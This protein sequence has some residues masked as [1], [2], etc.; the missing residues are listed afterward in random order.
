MHT[1]SVRANNLK[2]MLDPKSVAVVGA[3][4]DTRKPGGRVV[5]YLH[6]KHYQGKIY[7]VN[8]KVSFVN[9]IKAFAC[10]E[11]LPEIPDLVVISV[12]A[13][14]VVPTVVS[15]NA[16]GVPS[17]I[18]FS[19][20][21]SEVGTAEGLSLDEQLRDCINGSTIVSGPNCQGIINF[22]TGCIANFSSVMVASEIKVGSVGIVSQ[23][24]LFAALII[25]SLKEKSGIGYVATTGNE[26]DVEFSD[27]VAVMAED[28]KIKVIVGYLEAIRDVER[29]KHAARMAKKNNKPLIIL[30]VGKTKEAARAAQS[31]TGALSSPAFL[32]ES[33]FRSLDIIQV[34]DLD[35]LNQAA[36][37]LSLPLP[38]NDFSNLA[39]LTNSGGLGVWC[40]DQLKFQKFELANLAGSTKDSI[41]S[42]MFAFGSADNPVDIA[43]LAISNMPAVERILEHL[44]NDE[45]VDV[46]F[47]ILAF[48]HANASPFAQKL[49]DL[50]KKKKKTIV[51]CWISSDKE[52]QRM[53]ENNSLPVFESATEALRALTHVRNF[54]HANQSDQQSVKSQLNEEAKL[55]VAKHLERK[56]KSV[57]EY[58]AMNILKAIDIP[59][60]QIKRITEA[61][62]VGDVYKEFN[63]TVVMKVDSKNI[64]HKSD[65]G[66]VVLGVNSESKAIDAYEKISSDVKRNCPNAIINGILMCQEVKGIAEIIVGGVRDPI[67]GPYIMVGI[68]GIYAEALKDVVFRPA[69]ISDFAASEMLKELKMYSLLTGLR[70]QLGCDLTELTKIIS[71]VSDLLVEVE[72]LLEIDLNPVVVGSKPEQTRVVDALMTFR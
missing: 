12:P 40:T 63:S 52:A 14:Q 17:V 46:V 70:G 42:N 13:A 35:E 72:Q 37:M 5:K 49:I 47:L 43:T 9:D 58:D 3:S 16:L 48:T 22:H 29:F 7:P 57:G 30:K 51:V 34:N 53:L 1:N 18:I 56:D 62:D 69:P 38:R 19:S 21:F 27:M 6:D 60:P 10:L 36:Y 61:K 39:L 44:Y 64:H 23:S 24:G 67:L 33:L 65:V 41:Q 20:G 55:K 50:S 32:Y 8:P 2:R 28:P 59:T 68:G 31:H 26:I 66:G 71:K 45:N 25:D 11:D 54:Q 15:C 4:G